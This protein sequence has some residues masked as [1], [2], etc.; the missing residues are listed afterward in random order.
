MRKSEIMTNRRAALIGGGVLIT[1]VVSGLLPVRAQEK[2]KLIVCMDF[3]PTWKQ[4]AFH[5]AKVKGWYDAAGL[6]VEVKDGSGSSVTI[7]QAAAG[8]CDIG[9]ASLSSMVV[10]RSKGSDIVAI[11]RILEKN[12]IGMLIDKKLGIS[13]PKELAQ[14]NAQIFFESTSF[15]SLFPPF[16]KE[17]GVSTDS[18]KLVPMSVASA[19]GTY[20]SGQGDGL[21]TT[22]PYAM[23][24]AD[25]Q[26]PSSA[27]MFA[28]H[29]LPLP[30]HGLVASRATLQKRG[31]AIRNFLSVSERAWNQ[32]WFGDAQEAID[33]LVDQR[34]QANINAKLELARL[35]A[36]KPFASHRPGAGLLWMPSKDWNLAIKVMADAEIIPTTFNPEDFYTNDYV[37]AP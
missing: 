21:I 2:E 33:A 7:Q 23:P 10:A 14:K 34:P 22:V 36:Y 8:Q 32:V 20:L 27:V 5:L 28:D 11:G 29:G 24:L 16:F 30:S 13:D 4:A 31:D 1:S 19:V 12:D 26:R 3:L 37:P 25:G 6:D 35:N 15:Q 17:L 9:L 18:I